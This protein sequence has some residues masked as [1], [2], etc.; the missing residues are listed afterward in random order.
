MSEHERQP[1][2]AAVGV[3]S[4]DRQRSFRQEPHIRGAIVGIVSSVGDEAIDIVE[5]GIVAAID[6]DAAILVEDAL[7]AF[8]AEAA[9]RGVLHRHRMR[10]ERI[11]LD[12]PAEAVRL[13]RLLVDIEA[14]DELAPGLPQARHAVALIALGLSA[15]EA[16]RRLAALRAEF[17]PEIAVEI[18]LGGEI[19]APRRDPS[20]A[21]VERAEDVPA[22]RIGARLH[23]LMT[24]RRS[25][26]GHRRVGGADAAVVG[27]V[28]HGAPPILA[29]RDLDDGDAMGRH[30]DRDQLGRHVGKA[31]Q[32]LAGDAGE[33]DLLVGIFVID[34]EKAAPAAVRRAGRRRCSR[35]CNR[36]ASTAPR[37]SAATDRRAGESGNSGSPHRSSTSARYPSATWWVPSTPAAI[38]AK[39]KRSA[40]STARAARPSEQRRSE[41]RSGGGRSERAAHHLAPAVAPQD[42]VADGVALR[43]A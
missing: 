29:L 6:D 39:A 18:F 8:V 1:S 25:I 26:D 7:G 41:Q 17:A 31:D 9:E 34:A 27:A 43:R 20:G 35:C 42:D 10:I 23:P 37:R 11:D 28:E 33:H 38:S 5:A 19:G 14:V 30:F 4:R 36:T 32:V 16:R 24:G 21:I 12:D 15:A 3:E 13:V 40:A 2:D 22:R